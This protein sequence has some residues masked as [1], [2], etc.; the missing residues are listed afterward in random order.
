[1]MP[2]GE[3]HNE[4]ALGIHL[5]PQATRHKDIGAE[6]QGSAVSGWPPALLPA[7]PPKGGF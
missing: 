7:S 1:M 2:L 3:L 5:M 4:R 6:A